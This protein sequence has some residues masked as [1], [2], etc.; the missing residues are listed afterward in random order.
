MNDNRGVGNQC[1]GV[2]GISGR[3]NTLAWGI[4]CIPCDN[5]GI[6]WSYMYV[7]NRIGKVIK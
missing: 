4:S 3:A 5:V 6:N 2:R 7:V 1:R